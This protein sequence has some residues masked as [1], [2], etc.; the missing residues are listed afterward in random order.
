MIFRGLHWQTEGRRSIAREG[1]P[2]QTILKRQRDAV[3]GST[4]L[5][6]DERFDSRRPLTRTSCKSTGWSSVWQAPNL[7]GNWRRFQYEKID[8]MITASMSCHVNCWNFPSDHRKIGATRF[9]TVSFL[10]DSRDACATYLFL[11]S[12]LDFESRPLSRLLHKQGVI[13]II[14]KSIIN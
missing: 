8:I 1:S 3:C 14:P 2:F 11:A 12:I 9:P 13:S 10:T 5:F 4:S 7:V 6:N